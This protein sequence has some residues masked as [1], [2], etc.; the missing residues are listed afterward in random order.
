VDWGGS[1]GGVGVHTTI[2]D[3]AAKLRAAMADHTVE[4]RIAEF[5]EP[6]LVI[7][8]RI[9]ASRYEPASTIVTSNK[10]FESWAEVFPDPVIASAVL[11][12]LVHH[13][14]LVP[15]VGESFRM[16]ELKT[17]RASKGGTSATHS[18]WPAIQG[19]TAEGVTFGDR[20]GGALL[21]RLHRRAA[22]TRTTANGVA[23]GLR[24]AP[25]GSTHRRRRTPLRAP[26]PCHLP[27]MGGDF[28]ARK[29]QQSGGTGQGQVVS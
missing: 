19:A 28:L 24:L 6:D 2:Q 22:T 8:Y 18:V 5:V 15:I 13:A 10:S 4:Q 25:L 3:L 11:D 12:R 9:V 27:P 16:K 21:D 20:R 1:E 29:C 26:L 23:A 14:H 7:L 17:R